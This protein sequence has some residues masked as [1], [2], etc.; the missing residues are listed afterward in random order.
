MANTIQELIIPHQKNYGPFRSL[1][2]KQILNY[3]TNID[4]S[5]VNFNSI[6][7]LSDVDLFGQVVMNNKV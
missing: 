5:N 4:F 7:F 3:P 6:D 1:V 2:T